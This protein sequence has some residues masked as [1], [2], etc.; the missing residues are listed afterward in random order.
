M[1]TFLVT[2]AD[3]FLGY[4]TVKLLNKQSI[5]PR[6]LLPADIDPDLPGIKALKKLELKLSMAMLMIQAH[7]E[8]HAMVSILFSIYILRLRWVAVSK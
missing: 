5:R 2:G 3:G 4:H 1:K 6:V 8:R 7:Y